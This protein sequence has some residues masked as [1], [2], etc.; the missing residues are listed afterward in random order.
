M[1]ASNHGEATSLGSALS[2]S[3]GLKPA[4]FSALMLTPSEIEW[5]K[6]DSQRAA[7]L[8]AQLASEDSTLTSLI[9]ADR[10]HHPNAA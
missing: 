8:F 7:E 2:A 10:Q 5:L 3:P 1:E 6:Q 9:E 4:T